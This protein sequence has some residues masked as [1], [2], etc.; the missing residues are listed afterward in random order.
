MSCSGFMRHD[1]LYPA[2]VFL[3]TLQ[4]RVC[5]NINVI[6]RCIELKRAV[7]LLALCQNS[8]NVPEVLLPHC[9]RADH[10]TA[11][12]HNASCTA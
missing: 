9:C 2:C 3:R 10:A 7:A 1:H 6:S 11:A 4:R 5:K 8:A 12:T